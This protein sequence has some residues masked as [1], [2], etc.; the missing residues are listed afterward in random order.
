MGWTID[1][2]DWTQEEYRIFGNWLQFND[3]S[4]VQ[5]RRTICTEFTDFE[6]DDRTGFVGH[7]LQV[8]VRI[9][10]IERIIFE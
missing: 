1:L 7:S 4:D 2:W 9:E 8:I 5:K 6:S 3:W 10:T